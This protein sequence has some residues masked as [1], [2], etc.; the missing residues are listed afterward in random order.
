MIASMAGLPLSRE[1][2]IFV[3]GVCCLVLMG[4]IAPT[5]R[6]QAPADTTQP[7]PS[8]VEPAEMD[9]LSSEGLEAPFRPTDLPDAT[10]DTGETD[11]VFV[12][13][14]S[15]NAIQQDGERIQELFGN[16][17]V[18]QDTTRLQS[19]YA[20]R[21]LQEGEL[22]FI[23]NVVVFGREDTLRADSVRYDRATEVGRARGNVRLTDGDVTVRADRGTYYAQEDRS[24]FPDSVTLVDSNRVLRA[25]YG[26]YWSDEKRA[27]FG[28]GVRLTEPETKI[29]ADSLTFYRERD[30]SVARGNVFIDRWQKG[31]DADT[32]SRTYLFGNRVDNREQRRYSR[33][34][35][36]ALLLR[37]RLDS[38]GAPTDTLVVQGR[39]LEAFRT[40]THRR[41]VAVDSVRI[42]QSDLAAVADSAVY[43]RVT[44][45]T[46]DTTMG[47]EVPIDTSRPPPDSIG[48]IAGKMGGR[49]TDT[50]RRRPVEDSLKERPGDT[51][52][53]APRS[54][55]AG[56]APR[57][58]PSADGDA[59]PDSTSKARRPETPGDQSRGW[60]TPTAQSED[61]LPR[62][63]IRLYRD[64]VTWFEG[65]QASG[66][67]IRV[68]A[69]D[70]SPDTVFVRGAA[71]AAR[72]DS[73]LDR[74]HQLKA[75]NITAFFRSD[76]L[77]RIRGAP[78]ARALR[79]LASGTDSLSGAFRA[80]GDWVV[81]R[82]R[83]GGGR[84]IK[85]GPGIQGRLYRKVENI[86]DPFELE[87]FRWIPERRPT[88]AELLRGKRV[89]QRLDLEFTPQRPIAQQAQQPSPAPGADSLDQTLSLQEGPP[90]NVPPPLQE[91]QSA[92]EQGAPDSLRTEPA[93]RP[94]S[95][96]PPG[97][98]PVSPD[99]SETDSNPQP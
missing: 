20:R 54:T 64:P 59:P 97:R 1:G 99:T 56:S 29:V 86:P 77:R 2:G 51:D 79:F 78:N 37:V 82:F 68:R 46:E 32:T 9:T 58:S 55:D 48:G 75:R 85:F 91:S 65:S 92:N 60:T 80:S 96:P 89:R 67:S 12:T 21:Y 71:F 81:L 36:R 40:D 5:S 69:R 49:S 35:G 39:R 10:A 19:D 28:G 83:S 11:R 25:R 84:R 24:V 38:T 42:W 15:L 17:F 93:V 27:E 95:I 74:I 61:E 26:T 22:L 8:G 52:P 47:P 14:D 88:R 33:V 76:S 62:E 87:G 3:L 6:A 73:A 44:A 23:D 66:D 18:R 41:L 72:R 31:P 45:V 4:G 90:S 53:E 34:E 94:D 63:E 13:A 70:R 43:D 50:T 7:T 30:R 16:V 98:P 57:A